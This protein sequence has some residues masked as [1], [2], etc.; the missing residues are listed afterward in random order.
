[1]LQSYNKDA[2]RASVV[3]L[4]GAV[5]SEV[6][7]L[8][9]GEGENVVAYVAQI[10]RSNEHPNVGALVQNHPTTALPVRG[11]K[12]KGDNRRKT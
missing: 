7:R 10:H 3:E 12:K 5:E 6:R 8:Y 1:M 9:T 11:H 2:G 4:I